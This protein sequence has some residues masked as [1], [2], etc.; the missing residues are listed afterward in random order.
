MRPAD[1]IE[2]IFKENPHKKFSKNE[3]LKRFN[4]SNGEYLSAV[5]CL[6]IRDIIERIYTDRNTKYKLKI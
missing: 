3:I 5:R 6:R 4:I 1:E 2:T